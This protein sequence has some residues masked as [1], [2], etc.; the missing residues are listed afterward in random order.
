[1]TCGKCA[2]LTFFR[3]STSF[4]LIQASFAFFTTE[5]LEFMNALTYGGREHG[6]YP[7]SIYGKGV[8]RFLTFVVPLALFQYYPLLYLLGR[9]NGILYRLAPAI[10][11]LFVIPSYAFFRFGLRR[12]RSTGS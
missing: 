11:L 4:R 6:R 7:F 2:F 8:L 5:G 3:A 10:G 12:Y 1:M 9:E